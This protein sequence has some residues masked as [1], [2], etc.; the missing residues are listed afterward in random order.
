MIN[1]EITVGT[2]SKYKDIFF[3]KDS[4]QEEFVTEHL[5]I[6]QILEFLFNTYYP[7]FTVA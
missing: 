7:G 4:K 6:H 1:K 5:N 2:R 3:K